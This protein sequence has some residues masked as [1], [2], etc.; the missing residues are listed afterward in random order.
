MRRNRIQGSSSEKAYLEGSKIDKTGNISA[1]CN[2]D[3]RGLGKGAAEHN[4]AQQEAGDFE[5]VH[6]F[7]FVG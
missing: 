1:L 3:S 2:K 4:E 7:L 6:D 5:E